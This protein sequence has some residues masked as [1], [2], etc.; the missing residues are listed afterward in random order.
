MRASIIIPSHNCREFLIQ[1]L[2]SIL[3][4]LGPHDEVVIVDDGSSDGTK[5]KVCPFLADERFRYFYQ[6]ASG[7]PASPR[8]VGALHARGEYLFF[9]DSDDLML[10]GKVA[11]T[12]AAFERFPQSALIFTNFGCVDE[13][14]EILDMDF[15]EGYELIDKIRSGGEPDVALIDAHTACSHLARQNFI[16]TS[17]VAIRS[18]VFSKMGGFD[19]SLK[20]GDDK[21]MWF[22]ITRR[23]PIVYLD[24]E[25][26]LYRIRENSISRGG[27]LKRADARIRVLEKQLRDPVSKTFAKDIRHQIA[28]NYH[29]MAYEL[30]ARG[31]MRAS[32]EALVQALNHNLQ[33][34]FLSLYLKSLLGRRGVA[35]IR[36]LKHRVGM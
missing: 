16:G 10:P 17:G 11:S 33:P 1:T 2:E 29:S 20:N 34:R 8:N 7:G 4:E 24:K 31:D 3:R 13:N 18:S 36:S 14:G 15:L 32:R 28:L 22:R 23:Y 5:E 12:V 35:V 26:H 6:D 19:E 27:A 30:F 9:F 21:D 25:Y